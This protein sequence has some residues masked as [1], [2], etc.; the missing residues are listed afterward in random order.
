[1]AGKICKKAFKL[2]ALLLF[3][4]TSTNVFAETKV[5]IIVPELRAPFKVIFD[6]IGEGVDEELNQRTS[7][8]TLGKNYDPQ[9]IS[10]WIKKENINAVITLGG[11]GQKSTMYMPRGVPVVLGALSSSPGAANKFSGV[12]LTPNPKSLFQLLKRLDKQRNKIVVVYNPANNQWL[13]DLAKRQAAAIGVQLA[14]YQATGIKQAAIIYDKIFDGEIDST[15]IWLLQDRKV[16]DSKIVL[17]FILEKAWQKK[18]VVFSSALNHVKKGVLFSMYPDNKSHGK[19]LAKLILSKSKATSS[20]VE[21]YP[22][23]GLQDAVNSRTAEHLGLNISR[24]ELRE[25]DVVFPVSN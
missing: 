1:M 11:V 20:E 4:L 2:L 15:A 25:F 10:R 13:V 24:S 14:A 8:L 23:E 9:L 16:V 18:M 12:A 17:P 6:T 22:S 21:L 3:A 7:K 5:G 19:Q